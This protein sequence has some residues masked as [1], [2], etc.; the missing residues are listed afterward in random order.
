[1]ASPSQL[2]S[3]SSPMFDTLVVVGVGLIGGSVAA[4][5]KTRHLARRVVGLGR[6]AA[7]LRGAVDRGIVDEAFEDPARIG[8][9]DLV[10]ACTPVDRIADDIRRLARVLP[11]DCLYTDA[12]SVKEPICRSLADDPPASGVFV[13]GHPLAGSE[14]GGWEHSD[15][16]LF[17]GKLCVVTPTGREP[18]GAVARTEE[19]WKGLGMLVRR[20]SPQDHDTALALTS[21]LPHLVASALAAQLTE[22]MRPFAARGFRDT[23]RIAAGDPDL[24]TSIFSSN[25]EPLQDHLKRL[26]A[27]LSQFATALDRNDA[28]SLRDLLTVGQTARQAIDGGD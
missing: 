8:E 12:G 15:A 27:T 14:K 26:M 4:A 7:K 21:H 20:M 17:Q 10:V 16:E 2:S 5:A 22:E 18:S 13:G 9:A 23:T 3:T 1:M 28:T 24:W 25:T 6:S 19:F 11:A